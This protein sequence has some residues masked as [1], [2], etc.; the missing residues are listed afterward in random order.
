[1][2]A[3]AATTKY[4]LPLSS[5]LRLEESS[6]RLEG[7]V[8]QLTTVVQALQQTVGDNI[9]TAP[10]SVSSSN[11]KKKRARLLI[12]GTWLY[13]SL[14]GR[15]GELCPIARKF[16]IDW[17]LRYAIDWSRIPAI[18]EEHVSNELKNAAKIRGGGSSSY[19]IEHQRRPSPPPDDGSDGIEIASCSVFTSYRPDTAPTSLRYK[20]FEEM[21]K[22]DRFEVHRMETLG[23]AEK[24]V[25]IA[26]AVELLRSDCDAAFLLTGD[27]DFVPAMIGARSPTKKL[28]LVSM[29]RGCNRAL[30]EKPPGVIM[31]Y[32]VIWL[33]DYVEKFVVPISS[34]NMDSGAYGGGSPLAPAVVSTDGRH[35]ILSLYTF[36]K[37]LNDFIEHSPTR[38]VSSRDVGRYF[39]SLSFDYSTTVSDEVKSTFGSLR[40]VVR[41]L[42][43]VYKI[44]DGTSDELSDRSFWIELAS[45]ATQRLQVEAEKAVLSPTETRFFDQY[46]LRILE[47]KKTIYAFTIA[48]TR[49]ANGDESANESADRPIEDYGSWKVSQLKD[50]C[51]ELG[52]PVS[53]SCCSGLCYAK[54]PV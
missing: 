24:C 26:L 9:A 2:K 1:M 3:A 15:E 13:Y 51:R 17:V 34:G 53:V 37:I 54:W 30:Y 36:I 42:S 12:D 50:L 4:S 5:L 18:V 31:D 44:E 8:R 46:S 38:R 14:Y 25:D 39:K 29:R 16:G 43:D 40:Q 35:R 22:A 20:M 23:D 11:R 47:D 45:T 7:Q 21:S 10:A 32:N 19:W 41:L 52:L 49:G 48:L 6:R 28:G 33:D 27:R